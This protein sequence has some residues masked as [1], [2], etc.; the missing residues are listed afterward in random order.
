MREPNR[1]KGHAEGILAIGRRA[2]GL[3]AIGGAALGIVAVGRAAL[4]RVTPRSL[5]DR[6]V[7]KSAPP[8][9]EW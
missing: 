4:G 7:A 6:S 2:A 9:I 1:G 8:P 3:I 5:R